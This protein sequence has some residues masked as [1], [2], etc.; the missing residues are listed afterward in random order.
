MTTPGRCSRVRCCTATRASPGASRWCRPR[1][2]RSASWSRCEGTNCATRPSCA[3]SST[4][5][6]LA[7]PP[8][9]CT[10]RTSSGRRPCGRDRKAAIPADRAPG[11]ATGLLTASPDLLRI[12]CPQARRRR[13][14]RSWTGHRRPPPLHRPAPST[15]PSCGRRAARRCRHHSGRPPGGRSPR[16]SARGQCREPH[17]GQRRRRLHRCR[18][19]LAA[20]RLDARSTRQRVLPI[21]HGPCPRGMCRGHKFRRCRY[22]SRRP[23]RRSRHKLR[24]RRPGRRRPWPRPCPPWGPSPLRPRTRTGISRRRSGRAPAIGSSTNRPQAHGWGDAFSEAAA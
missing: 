3:R 12:S 20:H 9:C 23:P 17:R 6:R 5:R 22:P 10:T 18:R 1:C 11:R 16:R 8:P 13:R 14:F 2:S 19:C 15:G 21:R 7:S 24:F 4:S